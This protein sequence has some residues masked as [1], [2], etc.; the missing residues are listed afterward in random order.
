MAV[1]LVGK[2]L[3]DEGKLQHCLNSGETFVVN[4][5]MSLKHDLIGA[6]AH[7]NDSDPGRLTSI[8]ALAILWDAGLPKAESDLVKTGG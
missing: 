6:V 8:A 5:R 7:L 3:D 4:I 1:G 2:G